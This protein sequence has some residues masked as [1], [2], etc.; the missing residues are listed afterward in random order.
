MFITK[1]QFYLMILAIAALMLLFSI[2]VQAQPVLSD[3]NGSWAQKPLQAL[4]DKGVIDGYPDGTF[5]PEQPITRAEFSKLVAKAF[6]YR[7]TEQAFNFPDTA[8]N[9]AQ[10][11]I[12][13][14]AA[15]KVMNAFSDGTFRPQDRLNRAQMATMLTRIV[16]LG[17][18]EEKYSQW[19]ASF[20]D[21]PASHWAF[22]NIEIANKLG[23]FPD[24]YK[25]EFKPDLPVT[26]AEAAWMINSLSSLVIT[27]GKITSVNPDTGLVNVK[28]NNGDPTL[29]MITPDTIVLRNNAGSDI[30]SLLNGD[31]ATVISVPSG[32]VRFFKSFGQITKNDLLSRLSNM[33]KG[34]LTKDEIAAM[35]AGDWETVKNDLKG[36]LYNKLV[37]MGLSPDQAD[38]IMAQDWNYLDTVSRDNL[39]QALSGRLG[40]SQDFAQALLA[41]D[42]QKIK[43]YGKIELAT[44]ALSKLLG[45]ADNSSSQNT[46]GSY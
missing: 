8:G 42:T 34:K 18:P 40:V 12:Q 23:V 22:Q 43:E 46:G 44:A 31:D 10:I 30:D 13:E 26:R 21:V 41:R 9:W 2:E 33:T 24:S 14:V 38:G 28:S 6:D 25:T 11:F 29:A 1:R 5:K 37:D 16:Q 36:D 32:D 3:I 7:P 19:Q 15:Q 35:V 39:A 45:V 20:T 17:K 4:I 27:K